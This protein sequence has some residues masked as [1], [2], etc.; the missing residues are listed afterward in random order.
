MAEPADATVAGPHADQRRRRKE[1]LFEDAGGITV[2][3]PSQDHQISKRRLSRQSPIARKI[4]TFNLLAMGLL[5]VG[6]QF[7]N[8]FED[9]LISQRETSLITEA[10]MVSRSMAEL[11]VEL[12][13]T[14]QLNPE[15]A[16]EGM[17]VRARPTGARGE[18][19]DMDG[20]LLTGTDAFLGMEAKALPHTAEANGMIGEVVRRIRNVLTPRVGSG[21]VSDEVTA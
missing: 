6:V 13:P 9:N 18:V 15:R 17:S 21:L 3:L 20:A 1:P 2:V 4:F 11:A 14:V 16:Q 12:E 10:E 19:F 5:M 8:Q 7:L